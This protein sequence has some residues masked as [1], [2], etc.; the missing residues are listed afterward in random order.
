MELLRVTFHLIN[1]VFRGQRLNHDVSWSI[2]LV[3]NCGK[4]QQLDGLKNM[5]VPQTMYPIDIGDPLNSHASF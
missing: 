4:Y 2:T 3:E 1:L 5:H